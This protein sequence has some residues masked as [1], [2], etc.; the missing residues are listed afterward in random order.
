MGQ[1]L[2]ACSEPTICNIKI[3][4]VVITVDTDGSDHV[5]SITLTL[6]HN[7]VASRARQN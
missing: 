4:K 6:R 2:H 3:M 1:A 5:G 7:I